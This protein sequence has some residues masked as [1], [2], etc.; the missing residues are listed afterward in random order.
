MAAKRTVAAWIAL[1][2]ILGNLA[3][4]GGRLA[5]CAIAPAAQVPGY[6]TD[7]MGALSGLF[8]QLGRWL[9]PPE[10]PP[11]VAPPPEPPPV[12]IPKGGSTMERLR[13]QPKL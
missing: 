2:V 7:G 3:A 9:T 4:E 8:L 13:Q 1:V 11:V 12:V 6:C 5:L 10:A